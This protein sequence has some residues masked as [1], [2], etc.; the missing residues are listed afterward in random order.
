[1]FLEPQ[2]VGLAPAAVRHLSR[3]LTALV[4]GQ[5]AD[6]RFQELPSGGPRRPRAPLRG[7]RAEDGTT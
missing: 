5:A 3:T 7:T 1:Q 6:L 2:V 4:R